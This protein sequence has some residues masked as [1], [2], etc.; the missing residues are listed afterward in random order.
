MVQC[1][2][3]K[4]IEQRVAIPGGGLEFG[5]ELHAHI[6]RVNRLWQFDDLGQLLA[7]RQGRDHQTGFAQIV[8]VIHVGLVAVAVA[9][10]DHVAI[11]LVRQRA[12]GHVGALRAQA[13]GAAQIGVLVAGFDGAV[14]I[15]PLG[16]EGD[17]RVGTIRFELGAV[18]I[19]QARHMAGEFNGGHLHAQAD[20]FQIYI[21]ATT[22]W[23]DSRTLAKPNPARIAHVQTIENLTDFLN[24]MTTFFHDASRQSIHSHS[25]TR[26]SLGT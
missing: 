8:Q 4:S 17:N 6:P 19:L 14:C 5:V 12:L 26:S 25:I 24:Q 3:D 1:R 11:N 10:G 18:S 20:T 16:D 21:N 2:F 9:L 15:L 7:L 13:H 22:R 23:Q